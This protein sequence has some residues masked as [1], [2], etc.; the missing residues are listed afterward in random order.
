MQ[1]SIG[2]RSLHELFWSRNNSG[3]AV[4]R[5][6]SYS[7]LIHKPIA[8]YQ[9]IKWAGGE[10]VLLNQGCETGEGSLVMTIHE[11]QG[12]T[13]GEVTIVQRLRGSKYTASCFM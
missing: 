6:R 4:E 7:H 13:Y 3:E 5:R 1:T 2:G 9:L 12:L 10:K 11:S 8:L